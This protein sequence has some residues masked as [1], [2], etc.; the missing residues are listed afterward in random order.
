MASRAGGRAPAKP[1]KQAAPDK[2]QRA[3]W[4]NRIVSL[5]FVDPATLKP[6]PG[7]WRTH[8]EAQKRAMTDAFSQLG[9]IE[10]VIVNK[11]T[12]HM[13]DGHMRHQLALE[14]REPQIP[15]LYVKLTEAE[16]RLALTTVNPLAELAVTDPEKLQ[17]LLGGVER[18]GG[19]LDELL[20]SLEELAG[21]AVVKNATSTTGKR[22]VGAT[23][24]TMRAMLAV[25][26]IAVVER[27]LAR[28]GIANRGNALV[29]ICREYLS[30]HEGDEGAEGQHDAGP[31][32]G[33]E[34]ELAEAA[35]GLAGSA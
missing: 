22:S 13:I 19:P 20:S 3:S 14:H 26:E 24:H 23:T 5:E 9:Y 10:A 35:A 29:T 4:K 31:Q 30:E 6:N 33:V 34:S 25:P 16:E 32:G 15:V 7:N 8:P 2:A 21:G 11:T 18:K 12:G 17:E 27:A 28:T 1:Q